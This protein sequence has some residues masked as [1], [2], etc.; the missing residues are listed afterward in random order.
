MIVVEHDAFETI[1]SADYVADFGPGA[2]RNGGRVVAEGTPAEPEGQPRLARTGRFLSGVE[3]IEV[4]R[5]RR[6]PQGFIT[7]KGAREH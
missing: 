7:V 1:E 4:P 6:K 2:G 3:R 5:A